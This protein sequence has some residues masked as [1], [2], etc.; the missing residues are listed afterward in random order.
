MCAHAF[1]AEIGSVGL[2]S[3][4]HVVFPCNLRPFACIL[5]RVPIQE[6][7][8]KDGDLPTATVWKTVA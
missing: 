7:L 6:L 5:R 8:S 3:I 1:L 2:L 4:M